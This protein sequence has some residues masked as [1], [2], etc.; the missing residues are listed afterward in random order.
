M[1]IIILL[2]CILSLSWGYENQ[3]MAVKQQDAVLCE[4][5]REMVGN[6]FKCNK[7]CLHE[8]FCSGK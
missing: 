6:L 7:L 8:D 5:T 3:I 1:M 2:S 4:I